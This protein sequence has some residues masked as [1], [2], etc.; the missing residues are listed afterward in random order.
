VV[1]V[2]SGRRIEQP[3]DILPRVHAAYPRNG[4]RGILANRR[5]TRV[6]VRRPRQLQMQQSL[7]R[8]IERVADF[9]GDDCLCR[10]CQQ[11]CAARLTWSIF[12]DRSDAADRVFDRVITGASAEIAFKDTRKVLDVFLVQAGRGHDHARGAETALEPGGL[13]ERALHR[14]QLAVLRETLDGGHLVAGGPKRR[15]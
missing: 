8:G 11:T 14:M 10:R 7:D 2:V 12:F 6:S 1:I 9:A 5:D 15:D 4:Q 13:H 3:R